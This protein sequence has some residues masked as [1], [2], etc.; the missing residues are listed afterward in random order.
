MLANLERRSASEIAVTGRTLSGYAIIFH[1]PAN[2]GA[3]TEIVEPGAV[4]RTL[5]EQLDVRALADHDATARGV[6]GRV[7]AGTLRLA[8]DARGLR[9]EVDL[10]DTS[11]GRD[12]LESVTR[13][14]V[15]G[16]SFRFEVI[17]P[18]GERWEQRSGVLTR[19][20]TD[21][22]IPEISIA[23]FPVYVGTEDVAVA[24]RS[25]QGAQPR[26]GRSIRWLRMQHT[27]GGEVS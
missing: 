24:M 13:R 7:S 22:R 1:E 21:L 9:F 5:R 8:K 17:K 15:R 2:L 14:D 19:R 3:F 10:P 16:A 12:L 23:A 20:L 18:G 26:T 6:L 25:W 27:A 4:D 11:V